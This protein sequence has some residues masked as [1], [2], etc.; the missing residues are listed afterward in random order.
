MS[1]T[2]QGNI[3]EMDQT[4]IPTTIASLARLPT[5]RIKA[6]V[7]KMRCRPVQWIQPAELRHQGLW[8][9]QDTDLH[10]V[11]D[12]GGQHHRQQNAQHIGR[13]DLQNAIAG[14]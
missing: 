14:D 6:A 4:A 1:C 2:N 8:R 13:D 9:D 3:E 11:P 12:E 7:E 5:R 10:D